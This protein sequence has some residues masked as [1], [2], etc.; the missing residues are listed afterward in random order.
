MLLQICELLNAGY[1]VSLY[2]PG[3]RDSKRDALRDG[4]LAVI[5]YPYK[6]PPDVVRSVSSE[7][8]TPLSALQD[9]IRKLD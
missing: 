9:C 3:T 6:G 4:Y 1:S 2:P 7:Q 5:V 8:S